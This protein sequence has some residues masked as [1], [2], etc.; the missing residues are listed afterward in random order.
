MKALKWYRKAAE[1]KDKD[2][3][4]S[5]GLCYYQGDGVQQ[6]FAEAFKWFKKAAEN[7][8]KEAQHSLGLCYYRGNGVQQDFAEAFKWFKKAAERGHVEAQFYLGDCYA[9]GQ[10]VEQNQ[11]K[12]KY[13]YEKSAWQGNTEA[14]FQFGCIC[15]ADHDWYEAVSC[16]EKAANKKHL[17]A[18]YR[19]PLC[20]L[21][22]MSFFE[23][24]GD[25]AKA[26]RW[27]KKALESGCKYDLKTKLRFNTL[28]LL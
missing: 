15:E 22:Q 17:G 11:E 6:D 12:A 2:A 4:Y 24:W 27:Y 25:S 21:D 16:Y 7:E 5:L 8:D 19:L 23:D 18:L 13:W 1:N 14:L 20:I 3:Q 9:K 28:K 26:L 10:G